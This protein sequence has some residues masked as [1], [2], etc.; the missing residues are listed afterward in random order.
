MK[1][2]GAPFASTDFSKLPATRHAGESGIELW[3][4]VEAGNVRIRMVEYSPGY[5][6]DHWCTR[7]H[8][9]LVLEGVLVT[10]LQDGRTITL[11]AGMTYH[12]AENAEPHRSHTETGVRLFIVD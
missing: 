6:A 10:E 4:T 1:I 3:R 8:V 2:E 5:R 11:D 7:G 9:M 12:V